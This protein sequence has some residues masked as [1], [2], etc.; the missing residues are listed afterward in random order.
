MLMSAAA[1]GGGGRKLC[2]VRRDLALEARRCSERRRQQA[3]VTLQEQSPI[4]T[5]TLTCQGHV[6]SAGTNDAAQRADTGI[7]LVNSS[8]RSTQATG[9]I[10][11]DTEYTCS[12]ILY[13][14][15]TSWQ[16]PVPQYRLAP[17]LC[18]ASQSGSVNQTIKP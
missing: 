14:I 5:S 2:L 8:G 3:G 16:I 10:K 17:C 18:T 7:W 11:M 6:T 1:E 13:C 12:S 9:S 4:K 15:A